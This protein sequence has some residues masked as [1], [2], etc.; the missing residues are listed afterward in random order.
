VTNR[1]TEEQQNEIIS[2]HVRLV[3]KIYRDM[4][5]NSSLVKLVDE[6][7]AIQSGMIGLMN[8]ARL[9]DPTKKVRFASYAYLAIRNR[10]LDEVRK[11]SRQDYLKTRQL[12]R[13][14]GETPEGPKAPPLER[15]EIG[16]DQNLGTI[17]L[18]DTLD[19]ALCA[20]PAR[21]RRFLEM[22]YGL[23]GKPLTLREIAL[24]EDTTKETVRQVLKRAR[25]AL[26]NQLY[27][28]MGDDWKSLLQPLT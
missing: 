14:E 25:Y 7:D 6:D 19:Q 16:L 24:K 23:T 3:Y 28:I 12:A 13:L 15:G 4:L 11:E 8:A 27:G 26:R 5:N 21:P 9:F 20:L 2:S 22:R 1:L 18:R 17:D 10:I